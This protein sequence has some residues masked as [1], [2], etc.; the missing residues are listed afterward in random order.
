MTAVWLALLALALAGPVP[1]ALARARWTTRAPRAAVVLWQSIAVAAVLAALGVVLSGPEELL[2]LSDSNG[3]IDVSIAVGI[4]AVL[5]GVIIVRL[6]WSLIRLGFAVRR[7]RQKHL[8]A[9]ELITSLATHEGSTPDLR[10]LDGALP[11]AY[12]VPGRAGRVV[13]S[14]AMFDLLDPDEVQAVVEHERAHLRARHDLVTEAFTAL[15]RA[16]PRFVRSGQALDS[17]RAL[18]EM[19]AD[20]AARR[21]TGLSALRRALQKMADGAGSLDVS[22]RIRRLGSAVESPSRRLVV[23]AYAAA[24]AVLLVPTL[25]IAV[26]WLSAALAQSPFA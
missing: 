8:D 1:D 26:P 18:L 10:V 15:H 22:I 4:A 11:F 24:V 3:P 20:D 7:H 19:V 21:A 5:A 23:G 14:S 16:F 17:V 6:V 25:V 2:R 12:C 13:L 9:L